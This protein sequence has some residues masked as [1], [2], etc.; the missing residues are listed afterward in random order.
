MTRFASSGLR[1]VLYKAIVLQRIERTDYAEPR[2]IQYM[3]IDH[4]CRDIGMAEQLLH[5]ADVI[6]M[7]QQ[8]R[9]KGMAQRVTAYFLVNA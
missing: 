6:A 8:V 5:R 7:I 1:I 9:R 4:R 2:L 3:G